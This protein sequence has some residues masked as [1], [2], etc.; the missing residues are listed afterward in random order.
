MKKGRRPAS[1]GMKAEYDFKSMSGGV[2]GKYA[3]RLRAGSNL[4]LLEPDLA[5]AF[6]SDAAV[7]NALRAALDVA[8]VVKASKRLPGSASQRRRARVTLGTKHGSRSAARR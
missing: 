2:R 4:V 5:V 8:S 6:P 1:D 7:N 3:K